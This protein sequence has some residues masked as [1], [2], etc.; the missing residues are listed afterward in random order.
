MDLSGTALAVMA[1]GFLFFL[2]FRRKKDPD[3]PPYI[4]NPSPVPTPVQNLPPEVFPPFLV[5]DLDFGGQFIIDLRHRVHGCT[6]GGEPLDETGA[7]DPDGDLLRYWF[8]VTGPNR[9][10]LEVKYSV[11]DR[12]G[13]K[14]SEEWTVR[15]HFPVVRKNRFDA[16]DLEMEQ[17][18]IGYCYVGREGNQ[19]PGGVLVMSA[20]NPPIVVEPPAVAPTFLGIIT[21][22]YKVRDPSGKMRSASVKER[23]TITSC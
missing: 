19:P 14:I 22:L 12:D 21:V 17:E 2:F 13:V 3:Q 8:E 1:I 11:F 4:P 20:C 5:G 18:A 10:G 6:A 9:G 23:V 16:M 7:Y 15:N